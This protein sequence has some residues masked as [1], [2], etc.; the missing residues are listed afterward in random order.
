MRQ[1]VS[2]RDPNGWR[3]ASAASAEG[4]DVR[5]CAWVEER[6]LEGARGARAVLSDELIH[7]GLGQRAAPGLVDVGPGGPPGRPAVEASAKA[8]R[9]PP[10]RRFQDQIEV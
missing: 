8:A 6:D 2:C 4:E 3:N 1:K 7:A 10:R 5:A 9:R